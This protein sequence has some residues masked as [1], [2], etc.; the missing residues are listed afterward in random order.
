M[1]RM[2]GFF[3]LLVLI[4]LSAC[5]PVLLEQQQATATSFSRSEQELGR[6]AAEKGAAALCNVEF[7]AGKDAYKNSIC[8]LATQMGCRLVSTQIEETWE[9]FSKAYPVTQL[10]C[11]FR[12]SQFLEESFQF[13]LPVQYWQVKLAAGEGWPKDTPEREYWLQVAREDGTWKLNRVL[14]LDEIRYYALLQSVGT[15][16]S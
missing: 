8:V 15:K 14:V 16:S 9:S 6:Q 4:A 2:A 7:K 13:G 3:L 1:R 10:G 5:K 12:S 11:E